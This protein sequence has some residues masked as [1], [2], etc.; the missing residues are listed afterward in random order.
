MALNAM[1]EPE[2][3]HKILLV[4]DERI[5]QALTRRWLLDLGFEVIMAGDGSAVMRL[6]KE[7]QPDLILLDLG[8]EAEDPFHGRSFDG[9]GVL[10]WMRRQAEQTK[11]P[12]VIVITGRKEPGLRDRALQAGAV[13]FFQKPPEK[14]RLLTAIQVALQ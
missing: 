4:E 13:A 12:P 8:L 7:E 11:P 5:T 3:K 1:T 6:V 9:F 2:P 14:T 10:E